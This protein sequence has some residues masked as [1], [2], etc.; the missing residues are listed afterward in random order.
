MVLRV[1]GSTD[2]L[3]KLTLQRDCVRQLTLTGHSSSLRRLFAFFEVN[4]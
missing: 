4:E 2:S 1:R 3:G